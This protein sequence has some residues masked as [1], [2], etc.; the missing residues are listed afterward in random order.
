MSLDA[1][2][3]AMTAARA[4]AAQ[5][6]AEVAKATQEGESIAD[7]AR[8]AEVTRQTVYRWAE[9]VTPEQISHP[10]PD[11]LNDALLVIGSL[12]SARAAREGLAASGTKPRRGA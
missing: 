4:A 1:V 6:R 7:I 8:A 11:V 2:R 9:E 10:L 5:L 12:P 3:A